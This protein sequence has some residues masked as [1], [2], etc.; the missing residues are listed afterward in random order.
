MISKKSFKV[1][2]PFHN[3]LAITITICTLLDL[4]NC[5]TCQL[6][7]LSP[8]TPNIP[9]QYC[10]MYQTNA[11]CNSLQ[12]QQIKALAQGYFSSR[13]QGRYPSLKQY[14]C[15]GCSPDQPKYT[16]TNAQGKKV[17]KVCSNFFSSKVWGA[18]LNE[19]TVKYDPCGLQITLNGQQ[20]IV[21]ASTQYPSAQDFVNSNQPIFLSD[22]LIEFDDKNC[23]IGSIL[24][25]NWFN[26]FG[27]LA[28]YFLISILFI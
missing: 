12:D 21:T 4:T 16:S 26:T 11:C 2:L 22:F 18:P 17:L 1:N 23:L 28:I 13:C 19:K 9:L 7:G 3:I 27:G 20:Q 6:T 24:K 14:F 25:I 8:S 10:T 5:Q 15:F